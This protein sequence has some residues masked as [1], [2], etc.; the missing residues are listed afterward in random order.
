MSS[1]IEQGGDDDLIGS[2]KSLHFTADVDLL[3]SHCGGLCHMP[4]A[5]TLFM[6]R[7]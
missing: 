7:S 1:D 5:H 3:Q 4:T 6:M 2:W